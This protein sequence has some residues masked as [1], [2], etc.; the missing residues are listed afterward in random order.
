M[1][2]NHGFWDGFPSLEKAESPEPSSSPPSS[3]LFFSGSCRE[4]KCAGLFDAE[5]KGGGSVNGAV[6]KLRR[7]S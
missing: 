6:D 4:L 1:N 2:R 7:M 3:P 5:T